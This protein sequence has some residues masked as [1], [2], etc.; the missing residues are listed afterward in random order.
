LQPRSNN[1]ETT[2]QNGG[3]FFIFG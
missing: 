3:I 1:F 2:F